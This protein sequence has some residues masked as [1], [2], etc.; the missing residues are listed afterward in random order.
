MSRLAPFRTLP[1]KP[2]TAPPSTLTFSE[3]SE[4][5]QMHAQLLQNRDFSSHPTEKLEEFYTYLR[6]YSLQKALEQQYDDA[7]LAREL[8]DSVL[9]AINDRIPPPEEGP[10]LANLAEAEKN[11]FEGRWN[12]QLQEYDDESQL[13]REQ[14]DVR[15]TE[16]RQKFENLWMEEMPRRYRKPSTQLLQLRKI[17]KSLAVSGSF[18]KAKKVHSDVEQLAQ[19]EMTNAQAILIH[20]YEIAQKKLRQ[21]QEQEMELFETTRLHERSLLLAKYDSE[22]V[23]IEH[24]ELVVQVRTQNPRK[25]KNN[26]AT[27]NPPFAYKAKSRTGTEDVLLPPLRPPNDPEMME[28]QKNWKRDQ[29]RRKL[30]MQKKN[31]EVVLLKYSVDPE[32]VLERKE[33]RRR[34]I[35]KVTETNGIKVV[36]LVVESEGQKE[37]VQN[38]EGLE[39]PLPR[40]CHSF[41]DAQAG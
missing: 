41:I 24:R 38:D 35:L 21:K 32:K 12:R 17:E 33:R 20:D 10:N 22:K 15:Q 30:G 6:Q 31:A 4:F 28:E 2:K 8:S 23:A 3:N 13:R 26:L 9:S 27:G 7:Q 14:L 11:Q 16:E 18:E 36:D 37:N 29:E 25:I 34:R 19:I 39:T 40:I 1:F 5:Q